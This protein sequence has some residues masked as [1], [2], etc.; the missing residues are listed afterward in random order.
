MRKY[1]TLPLIAKPNAGLPRA[2][3]SYDLIPAEFAAH[4]AELVNAGACVVGGCCGTT[5]E[6]I[7]LLKEKLLNTKPP[8][9]P[10]T[11]PVGVCSSTKHVILSR[12]VTV[13][14]RLNRRGKK[15]LNR[16]L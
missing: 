1:T 13:G 16:R 3:G 8:K 10:K 11:V 9:R 12:P 4:T 7:R 2:D 6:H 5:P 15:L 14:E